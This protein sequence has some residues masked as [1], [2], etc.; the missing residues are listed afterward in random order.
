MNVNCKLITVLLL[1]CLISA[2]NAQDLGWQDLVNRKQYA[3][4]IARAD[5]LTPADSSSY[6]V[7]NAIGQAYEGML[8][9]REAYGYYRLCL[10]MDT[11]NL[12]ILNTLARTA[13][14][15]GK[16]KDAE[17]Y[18]QQVLATDSLNFYANYQL[19]RLYSQLGEYVKAIGIYEKLQEQNPDNT[20]LYRAIGDCYSRMERYP[21]ATTAYF[22]AYNLNRENAGLAGALVNSMYRMGGEYIA[23]GLAICDT[24]LYYNPG[25]RPLLR[26]KG[27]GLYMTKEFARADS[28]YSVLL[29]DGDST[30]FTLKYG[31][32]SKYYAGLY[33]PSVE[34]LEKAYERDTTS[35][36]VCLLLGSALGKTYDRK[37]AYI[38]FDK[39]EQG[40][41]PSPLLVNQLLTFRA[42]TYW[43]DGRRKESAS[44]YYEAWK[45]NP[46]RVDFLAEI[47][48]MYG[49]GDV[50]KYKNQEERQRGLFIQ[51][52][53]MNEAL[54]KGG[55]TEALAFNR[56]LLQSFYEDMFFR[57]LSEE[58]MVAPDGKKSKISVVDLRGLINQLPEESEYG[59]EVRAS[60][61]RSVG[62]KDEAARYLYQAWKI[63]GTRTE[64]LREIANLYSQY[65][66]SG[67]KRPEDLQRGVFA[68]VM[69]VNDLLKNG[70]DLNRLT[71][72]RP[73]F[74]SLYADMSGRGATEQTMLS[75][76]NRKSQL[77]I[78]ELQSLIRQL[79]EIS[80][81][82]KELIRRSEAE[83]KLKEKKQK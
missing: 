59:L 34:I 71:F 16:A 28:V 31:G 81:G 40:L 1:Y 48:R 17:R 46:D 62:K 7:L 2:A 19:A 24:A 3:V 64:L 32:A 11:T 6:E 82:T 78:D 57:N 76:D 45:N 12:D 22:L 60:N 9:Y 83:K 33:L 53:Y 80:E 74:E 35:V 47:A 43:K 63:K 5:S 23:E 75:P 49:V 72:T 4:V 44:L 54:K 37:R 27:L 55:Y 68:H 36:E 26:N 41:Q 15:L 56:A 14:N 8:R 69:Y 70:L 38:L 67:F 51:V 13:T 61:L 77:S 42:E 21:D 79:P 10:D 25:N 73:L 39:A 30:Y 66:I 29:A 50:D 20:A 65:D 58:T 52:L 18:F